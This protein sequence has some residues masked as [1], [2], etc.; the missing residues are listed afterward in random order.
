MLI[1]NQEKNFAI[2]LNNIFDITVL[3]DGDIIVHENCDNP[4]MF[5]LGGYE[6]QQKV[7]NQ[8]LSAY[9]NDEKVFF[10]PKE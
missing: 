4:A 7:F 6:N 2:N 10:M 8:I 1:V 5:I 9:A 3:E